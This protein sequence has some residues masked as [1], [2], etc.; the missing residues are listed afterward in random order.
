MIKLRHQKILIGGVLMGASGMAMSF[1][2]PPVID[3]IWQQGMNAAESTILF[4]NGPARA[5]GA[6][7]IPISLPVRLR[8]V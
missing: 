8:R 2:C 1:G 6:L 3:S 7:R 5:F 4:I